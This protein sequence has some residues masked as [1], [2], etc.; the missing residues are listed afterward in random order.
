MGA[1][2]ITLYD[3]ARCPYCARVRIALAEKGI[4]YD[5]IEIDL[6]DRPGWLYE[7]NP[8]GKVP[9]VEEDGWIL[10]ESAVINEF[11]NE[12]HPEPPLWPDDPGE[13]AAGRLLVFR[14]DDFSTPYY[15][16]R[17]GEEGAQQRFE[18][19]LGFLDE[20][21]QRSTWLSGRAFGL[22]DIA[23]LPWVVRARDMLGIPLEAWPAL[24]AWLE[25]ASERPSVAA[26]L[27]LVASL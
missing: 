7:K 27:Q 8:A 4:P 1:G 17:R 5:P 15:G 18:A 19:E 24:A 10:P 12:R 11:L 26:E 21:L 23:F 6:A 13:R 3:A 2:V 25:R 20:L 14:F 22:A 16:L 9:V